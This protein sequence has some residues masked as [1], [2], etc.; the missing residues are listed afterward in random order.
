[1]GILEGLRQE[2]AKCGSWLGAGKNEESCLL[3][4]GRGRVAV[5][6]P[7]PVTGVKVEMQE[8]SRRLSIKE[9]G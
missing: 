5:P 2:D 1:M 4:T 7:V 8:R 6:V 3:L 9:W